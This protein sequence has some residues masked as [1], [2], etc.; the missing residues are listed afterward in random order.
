[1]RRCLTV[2]FALAGLLV[3]CGGGQVPSAGDTR[4][5]TSDGMVMVYVPA[6][7]Y[8]MGSTDNDPNAEDNEKPQHSVYLDAFWVDRTEVT[9]AQY[10]RCV[11]AGDCPVPTFCSSGEPTYGDAAKSDH[12]VVCVGW[13]DARAYCQWAGARLPTEAE[14]EK[15]ARGTDSRIY[16]WGNAFD[17]GRL[18]QCD[19]NCEYLGRETGA[20]DGY[21]RTAPVGSFPPGASPYGALDML[22]N[23]W[24]WVND[25]YDAGYYDHSPSRNPEGPGSGTARVVR[26]DS[27]GGGLP[28][29]R[30]AFRQPA[31]PVWNSTDNIG[32][33]CALSGE[34]SP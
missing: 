31:Q 6:G 1:M 18:N 33:R 24:E 16:P 20:D 26:G 23:V 14:W 27:W 2:I 17:G 19:A 15:A 29:A 30:C 32:F 7:K 9:N 8:P 21:V 22:G 11:E 25:W 10:G 3:G 13:D 5:R 34:S 4:V 28:T 12:P